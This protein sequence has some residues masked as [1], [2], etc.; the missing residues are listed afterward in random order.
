MADG[1][2]VAPIP[3]EITR[4]HDVA[5]IG[6]RHRFDK[7]RNQGVA[8]H[9]ECHSQEHAQASTAHFGYGQVIN[10]VAVEIT[11]DDAAA[12]SL[13]ARVGIGVLQQQVV[14]RPNPVLRERGGSRGAQGQC[15]AGPCQQ[16]PH[17]AIGMQC[18]HVEL[19][20][21]RRM[22]VEGLGTARRSRRSYGVDG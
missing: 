5:V 21:P 13:I 18:F 6:H 1:D 14:S 10:A 16:C 12:E 2:F 11:G 20:S 7:E 17:L 19:L 3:I 15:G 22:R 8:A 4:R 9:L